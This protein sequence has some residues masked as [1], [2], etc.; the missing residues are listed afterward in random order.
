MAD[1]IRVTVWNEF[2]HETSDDS[3]RAIYPEGIHHAIAGFL[4]SQPD[5]EAGTATLDQPEHGLQEEI[6]NNTDVLIWWGHKAHDEVSDQIVENVYKRVLDG[7]GLIV[8]HSGHYSKIFR[9]LM[10]TSC[11][12]KWREVGEKERL[13]VINPAHPIAEGLGAYIDIPRTEMYG[14]RFD[15]PQPDELV[16]I[17]WYQGGE[18]FRGGCCYNRGCGKVFYFSPGHESFPIYYQS[19]IQKVITNAVRWA[20]PFSG[21]APQYGKVEPLEKIPLE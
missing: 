6:L 13:W 15:I 14:E 7:M 5:I 11:S 16:F 10:G 4:N 17:S 19:E 12:L 8:L 18:V 21:P 3:I 9:K 2:R 1:K 20:K